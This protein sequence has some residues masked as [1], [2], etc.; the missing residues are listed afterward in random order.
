L[1]SGNLDTLDAGLW[2][3]PDGGGRA[4]ALTNGLGEHVETRASAD[5]TRSVA[6]LVDLRQSLE[7]IPADTATP[8]RRS[9]TNPFD[10]DV[11]PSVDPLSGRIVFSSA[12]SG[13]RN[14]WIAASDGSGATPL[15]TEQALDT[16]PVFSPDG[17][18]IA[19]ISERGGNRGIWLIGA[20]GGAP[21][22]LVR[23]NVLD[24]L[25]WSRD[26][27]RILFARPGGELPALASVTVADGRVEPFLTSGGAFSPTWSPTSDVIAYLEPVT[28]ALPP[29]ATATVARMY[30]R[31]VDPSGRRLYP[32]LSDA[33]NFANGYVVWSHDGRRLAAVSAGANTTAQ[34]WVI[35]PGS[36]QPF[37]KIVD[38]PSSMRPRGVAWAADGKTVVYGNQETESD[39]VLYEVQR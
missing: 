18:E 35:E 4:T 9:L 10:G 14:L 29:P 19:F 17:R 7:A 8:E 11:D 1:F 16:R 39:V 38:L 27:T 6:S 13:N 12:R 25:T 3:Q 5:G 37:R 26:G 20:Q 23:E 2:W 22:L 24:T 31:F 36:K 15:T 21:R 32:E 28:V 34:L 30:V 33:T